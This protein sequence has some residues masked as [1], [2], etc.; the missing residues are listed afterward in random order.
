MPYIIFILKTALEDFRRNK[1]RTFLASLGILIGVSSVVLLI[2]FGLGLKKY[3]KQQFE[4]LGTNLIIVL[5]GKIL[6]GGALRPGGEALGGAEFDEKDVLNLK[7]I[8]NTLYVIPV[9]VKTVK[10]DVGGKSELGDLYAT[11]ADMFPARNLEIAY[12]RLFEKSDV[13]KRAKNVVIGPKI[14]R[15]LFGSEETAVS[16]KITIETQRFRIIGVLK[17]KGGGFGG[18]DF[19]SF[20]YMPYKSAFSF[21]P[22]KTFFALYVKAKNADLIAETKRGIQNALEKRYKKDDF[23][24]IEQTELINAIGSIFSIFNVVIV[25]I[26][27]ISLVVGGIGI[28]NIMYV[29]VIERIREIGI[30]RAIGATKNDILFQ[31]LAESIILSLMGG[32]LGL[33]VAFVIVFFIQ[34]V[35]PAYINM[36]SIG[37]AIGV[38]SIIGVIFGVL[39]AKKAADLSPIEAIR[40]E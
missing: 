24:V 21:N 12:G 8:K 30:R 7:K 14:A 20:M 25:A 37:A 11:T 40:Y 23:S 15:E 35:F 19:D 16:K 22:N 31:F 10:A 9:F 33:L 6:Q 18:P 4:S 1:V 13:D 2:A 29:S 27:A 3:V 36:A 34:R 5:P 26:A 17:S 28:M 38:S 32:L 39:P